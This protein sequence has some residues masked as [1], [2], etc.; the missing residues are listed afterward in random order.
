MN[1]SIRPEEIIW[2]ITPVCNKNCVYCGSKELKNKNIL[3]QEQLLKITEEICKF[4]PMSINLSGGEV[5]TVKEETLNLIFNK[6]YDIGIEIKVIT[7]GLFI[8]NFQ[9]SDIFKKVNVIGISINNEKDI[10]NFYSSNIKLN[11]NFVIVTNFGKHNIKDIL[12]LYHFSK[13]FNNWQ[14]QLTIDEKLSLNM[15]EIK[16]LYD[17][18][19]SL[20][21]EHII[22]ADNFRKN[23]KCQAGIKGIGILY[24]GDVVPCLSHRSFLTEKEI[25][26]AGNL[27]NSSLK[28]I[29]NKGFLEWKNKCVSC[30]DNLDYNLLY[31]NTNNINN[32]NNIKFVYGITKNPIKDNDFGQVMLYGVHLDDIKC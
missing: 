23:Y 27:L 15:V 11:D 19:I 5:G 1:K 9:N 10:E 31:K 29:W 20:N 12:K 14:V 7:N 18:L 21:K 2:E 26:K 30:R 6:F 28:D 4:P 17:K 8:E 3:S 16:E 22:F 24:T 25:Y 32:I 13:L